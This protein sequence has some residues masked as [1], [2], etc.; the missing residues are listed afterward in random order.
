MAVGLEDR[1]VL[2]V[3][4]K[5]DINV[6]DMSRIHLHAPLTKRD[7]PAGARR[8]EQKADGYVATVVS[9]QIV[10]REGEPTGALPGRLV[11]GAQAAPVPHGMM[12]AEPA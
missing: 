1:G 5:A 10:Y 7:L 11:R 2:K 9:G 3:G 8:L 6:I 4:Y 12:A